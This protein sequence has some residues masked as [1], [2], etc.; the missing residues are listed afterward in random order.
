MEKAASAP[1]PYASPNE[2]E[3][4]PILFKG[5]LPEELL[6]R[7][8]RQFVAFD[9]LTRV[10]G[11]LWVLFFCPVTCWHI[12]TQAID[13]QRIHPIFWLLLAATILMAFWLPGVMYLINRLGSGGRRIRRLIESNETFRGWMN[14]DGVTV[15][16]GGWALQAK[17]TH[18]AAP[19]LFRDFLS[20]P[21]VVDDRS[22]L[23]LPWHFFESHDAYLQAR[24]YIQQRTGLPDEAVIKIGTIDGLDTHHN[25][26]DFDHHTAD[27]WTVQC[28]PPDATPVDSKV[29]SVRITDC[30]STVT[31][32]VET[33]LVTSVA[34]GILGV[35][36]IVAAAAWLFYD[37]QHFGGWG[38]LRTQPWENAFMLVP[39]GL[40][41][42][43]AVGLFVQLYTKHTDRF[44]GESTVA[45]SNHGFCMR[46]NTATEWC[47]WSNVASIDSKQK[48]VAISLFNDSEALT[49]P[50]A[51][52]A[53]LED[54]ETFRRD[55]D[56]L[57]V[58]YRKN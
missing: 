25:V 5:T 13:N 30:R 57:W 33:S 15:W 16:T 21:D 6:W 44:A 3:I 4:D 7:S 43:L 20:I 39:C 19:Q 29:T 10:M 56:Q 1:N 46:F 51:A 8:T 41:L 12:Y 54:F 24:T 58:Q 36:L 17:W 27:K 50:Q 34:V 9:T 14:S 55:I 35:P 28:W 38:F 37:Y 40:L 47:T 23:L 53:N 2:S 11:W 42:I 49:I 22:R 31:R 26:F 45:L 18:F 52:F 32:L 48:S